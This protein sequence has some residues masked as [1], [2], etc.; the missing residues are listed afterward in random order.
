MTWRALVPLSLCALIAG[1]AWFAWRAH[2]ELRPY[3]G[4]DSG[5]ATSAA[6]GVANEAA[7]AAHPGPQP[8][9]VTD[10]RE[11]VTTPAPGEATAATGPMVQVRVLGSDGVP[12]PGIAVFYADQMQAS[13]A[14][15][16]LAADER[17]RLTS[18]SEWF[19]QR[20]GAVATTDAAG[21][22][23][24]PWRERERGNWYCFSRRGADYGEAW[25][26]MAAAAA[27]VHDLELVED[28]AFTVQVVA[29]SQQPAAGVPIQAVFA[30]RHDPARSVAFELG[31]TDAEGRLVARHAQTW[32]P[33]IA[34]RGTMLPTTIGVKLP[35][36]A[37]GREI[38]AA[39]PPSEAIVLALPPLGAIELTVR[40]A[41]GEPVENARYYLTEDV[42]KPDHAY[43]ARTD[44]AG[45]ARLPFVGLGRQWR[46]AEQP[47]ARDRAQVVVG[48]RA[49][50]EV[51][52]V[53][54]QPDPVPVLMGLL[55]RDGVAMANAALVVTSGGKAIASG[56]PRTDEDGRFRIAV[57]AEW[58]DQTL[59][60]LDVYTSSADHGYDGTSA[61]WRG[62]LALGIGPHDL[63][64]LALQADAIVCAGQLIAPDGDAASADVKIGVETTQQPAKPAWLSLRQRR[65]EDGHFVFFGRPPDGALQL[66]VRTWNRFLPVP[67][68]PFVA[69]ARDL[70]IELHRGGSLR[71]SIVARTQLA[72]FCLQPR[73][74]PMEHAIEVPDHARFVPS[75][76]PRLACESAF[77][78]DEPLEIAYVWPA[79]APGRYRLEVGTR[80]VRSPILVIQDIVV[81]DGQRNEEARLQHLEV[82]GLRTIEI[83]LPQAEPGGFGNSVIFVL[84]GDAPGEQCWHMDDKTA[85]FAAV[86][87]LDLLVRLPGHR[88]RIVR[89]LV[90]N[91]TIELEPGIAVTLRSAAFSAPAG[92]IVSLALEG[93][94]DALTARHAAMYSA[95]AGGSLPPY[96][97]KPIEADLVAGEA[98]VRLPAPG[99]YRLRASLRTDAVRVELD[100]EPAEL[101][102]GAAGGPF[103]IT[104]R[105]R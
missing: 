37:V 43:G 96:R 17:L 22:A 87:P 18:D 7:S 66:T 50:G 68:I 53:L 2:T 40:D 26:S 4:E 94:D 19:L 101:R 77:V 82:P 72:A 47:G 70:R 84:E 92:G 1:G 32:Y 93:L 52:R 25:I 79:V 9:P 74:V 35:G 58:R 65:D 20:F 31:G 41:L 33:R 100:V 83:T 76:D 45:V 56:E 11:L 98:T 86:Q 24:W 59:T 103:P 30:D 48:P 38:D 105:P 44:A 99:R 60:A 23:R 8:A 54:L 64:V 63:G 42:V 61:A 46:L 62:A 75:L 39:R 15:A 81:A 95:A 21:V 51:V 89:G 90:A 71:A 14:S 97:L 16:T 102:V 73:L 69:G 36:V 67:P 6:A 57:R 88:D 12:M 49:A 55:Q 5:D 85:F 80:G 3:G 78:R 34:P 29:A 28:V 91:E 104:L 27:T 13:R 10:Q